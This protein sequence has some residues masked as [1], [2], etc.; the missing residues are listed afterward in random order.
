MYD[1]V[2]VGGGP[3]GATVARIAGRCGK[4]LLVER[5]DDV[6][7]DGPGR[8]K[9]CGGLLAPDAQRAL[10]ALGLGVPRHVLTGP[11]LFAVRAIDV[12]SRRERHYA[13]AY[14]NVDRARFDA[15]LRSLV[16]VDVEVR[17]GVRVTGVREHADGAELRLEG[18]GGIEIVRARLVVGAD[19]AGSRVRRDVFPGAPEPRRYVAI[20]EWFEARAAEPCYT[21]VFDPEVTDFY[22]WA[23]PKGDAVI[24]GAAI[25]VG[26]EAAGRFERLVETLRRS[27]LGLGPSLGREGTLL[28]RPRRRVELVTG[29]ARVALVGEAAGFVSPSSAE[30]ISFALE[31]GAALGAAIEAGGVEGAAERYRAATARLARKVLAKVLKGLLLDRAAFRSAALASG[32]GAI[33]VGAP[34][35]LRNPAPAH[36]ATGAAPT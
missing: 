35:R 13:R 31:S 1:V 29:S 36:C 8:G 33:P 2:V 14:L 21:A 11:Q 18:R 9:P 6:A 32:V 4:T 34:P 27:G 24:V 28:C 25:P 19:G 10:A 26:P 3:S 16:P 22:G 20:Q 12:P 23:I 5:R 17:R 7:R 30:G 15:W